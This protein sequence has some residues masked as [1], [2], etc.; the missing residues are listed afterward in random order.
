ME[1]DKEEGNLRARGKS[2][3][4]K[5]N[6]KRDGMVLKSEEEVEDAVPPQLVRQGSGLKVSQ[7]G[8]L[9]GR[10]TSLPETDHETQK[11]ISQI[12]REKI[13]PWERMGEGDYSRHIT[14]SAK[15]KLTSHLLNPNNRKSR[16][17]G[18]G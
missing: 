9:A 13:V 15:E 14:I 10:K 17:K 18:D 16:G 1:K 6:K 5:R 11:A 7:N 12:E 8:R 2:L 4:L 3:D